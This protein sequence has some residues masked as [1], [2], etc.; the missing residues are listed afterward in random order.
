MGRVP[1]L[2]LSLKDHCE[3]TLR[4]NLSTRCRHY[5]FC[6]RFLSIRIDVTPNSKTE[7]SM[8]PRKDQSPP[9]L[10][11]A[12]SPIGFKVPFTQTFQRVLALPDI[13]D[14]RY[15]LCIA[16]SSVWSGPKDTFTF[17]GGRHDNKSNCIFPFAVFPV[18]TPL[19]KSAW[20]E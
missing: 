12:L 6:L 15:I 2:K 3:S 7:L 11:E 8:A 4:P 10:L 16:K 1:I 14:K 18:W 20:V 5:R 9:K 17:T 13:A 19:N